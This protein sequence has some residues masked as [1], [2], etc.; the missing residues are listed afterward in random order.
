MVFRMI[1]PDY[2]PMP[3]PAPHP[4]EPRQDGDLIAYAGTSTR[5]N[6]KRKQG[7]VERIQKIDDELLGYNAGAGFVF[8]KL[9]EN[10]AAFDQYVRLPF[11]KGVTE[12][13]TGRTLLIVGDGAHHGEAM[14]GQYD[15]SKDPYTLE[16][17]AFGNTIRWINVGDTRQ[18]FIG[19][20]YRQ[21]GDKKHG[22][23]CNKK[24]IQFLA[25]MLLQFGYDSEKRLFLLDPPHIRESTEGKNFRKQGLETLLNWAGVR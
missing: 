21:N 12:R 8:I 11:T 17:K 22:V 4:A 13:S 10:D 7:H 6:P 14:Q 24:D 1:T 20:D 5:S 18:G 2:A 23:A 9:K 16:G 15:V 3:T 25:N 19:M